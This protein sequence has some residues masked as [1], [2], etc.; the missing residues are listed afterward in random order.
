MDPRTSK[1]PVDGRGKH[2]LPA[3]VDSRK[4]LV[5]V[6]HHRFAGSWWCCGPLQVAHASN[7]ADRDTQPHSTQASNNNDNG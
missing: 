7:N 2:V 5:E 4:R 3:H 6:K 1:Y